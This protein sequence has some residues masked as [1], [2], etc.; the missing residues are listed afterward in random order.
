MTPK[1]DG[2][3]CLAQVTTEI[4]ENETTEQIEPRL[5]ELGVEAVHDAIGM[6]AQWDGNSPIGEVQDPK[7]ATKAPRLNKS[8]GLVDWTK[9]A[10]QIVNQIRAFQPWPGTFTNWQAEHLK[11][12]MRTIIHQAKVVDDPGSTDSDS[13][14]GETEAINLEL[15][16]GQVVACNKNRLWIQTGD[17]V[18]SIIQI[19]PAGKK[20]MPIAD[21]LRGNQP[22][23]GQQFA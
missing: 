6:L 15:A 13:Q 17:G 16:P 22:V 23:T 19:Q 5:A 8:D 12:P 3:P 10:N 1:L 2:G 4:G 21:F 14:E 11:Q 7:L 18:L 20:P 9:S